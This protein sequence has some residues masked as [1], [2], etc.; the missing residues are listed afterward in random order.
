MS[1]FKKLTFLKVLTTVAWADG[2]M[3]ESELSVLK[4]F[5]RKF[6]L[7]RDE[8]NELKPYLAAPVSKKE[9]DGLYET[10]VGQLSSPDERKDIQDAM[11]A[12]LEAHPRAGTLER[13]LVEA[14]SKAL[15]KTSF[16]KRSL[17]KFR[18]LLQSTLFQGAR[19]KDPDMEK[20]FKRKVLNKIELKL[21]ALGKKISIPDDQVYYLCLLG[22]LLALV[23]NV[24]NHLDE[25]EQKALKRVLGD[26]FA[27]KGQEL[28]VLFDVIV[29]QARK[30][31]DF[32]EVVSE[33]NNLTPHKDRLKLVDSFF[34]VAAADGDLTHDEAEEVRRITKGLRIQHKDFIASKVK[35]LHRL[36]QSS[37]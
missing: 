1:Y 11:A 20:Y 36:R 21:S 25:S 31:F 37:R 16:T 17:V 10:L 12:M 34:A 35:F 7:G 4:R 24:D 29:E 18:N 22:S 6:D 13:D 14:F 2:E 33:L 30:G 23:A 26:Q 27:V 3:T 5:Y 32:H 19:E 15:D 8:L 28:Q 9:R